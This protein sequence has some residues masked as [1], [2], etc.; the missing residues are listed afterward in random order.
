MPFLRLPQSTGVVY[1]EPE[2]A[3][4]EARAAVDA[5][6]LTYLTARLLPSFRCDDLTVDRH[7][8]RGAAQRCVTS[9]QPQNLKQQG[10][11]ALRLFGVLRRSPC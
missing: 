4:A 10:G 1:A 3:D 7:C 11:F 2:M 8:Q 6:E 5:A 9:D